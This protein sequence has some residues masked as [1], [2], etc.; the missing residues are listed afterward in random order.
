M[1]GSIT[2]TITIISTSDIHGFRCPPEQSPSL[3]DWKRMSAMTDLILGKKRQHGSSLLWIDN[4]D[5]YQGSPLSDYYMK[6]I[7][8]HGAVSHPMTGW[9]A[10]AGCDAF[11]PG[12]HEFNY[13]KETIRLISAS[14]PC[15]WLCANIV[16]CETL[17]PFFGA[18]YRI[19]TNEAGVRVAVLGLTTAYI[20]H[21]ELPAHIEGLT[22]LPALEAAR[23]WVPYLR[24]QHSADVVIV[25]YHGGFES[26]PATGE[27][28]E[29][30]TGENEGFRLCTE[31]EGI[32][33]LL[34][35]HQHRR[36]ESQTI[37]G[38]AIV[39]P[40]VYGTHL[41]EVRLTLAQSGD[42][43]WVLQEATTQLIPVTVPDD[44][45]QP[46][47]LASSLME[48]N[49]WM[50][51]PLGRMA[52]DLLIKNAHEARL[53]KHPFVQWLNTVQMEA[54]G[55]RVALTALMDNHA[56]GF[57]T[58]VTI[59]DIAAN[60]PYPNTLT[61]RRLS[62]HQVKLALEH[63]ARYFELDENGAIIVHSSFLDPKPQPFHYDMWDG[64]DY[65]LDISRPPGE[66]VTRL[67]YDG[68]PLAMDQELEVAMNHYRASGSG[69]YEMMLD[70]PMVRQHTTEI[71]ELMANALAAKDV[72]HVVLNPNW[73]V[74]GGRISQ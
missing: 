54:A 4:G 30:W 74:T 62:G 34:T 29:V 56:P 5:L 32:D 36:I 63:S 46:D 72:W 11:V 9:L 59:R 65:T 58:V 39:Q 64:I 7:R 68:A 61:V 12:N 44:C 40:G 22:F 42:G 16:D 50:D 37:G 52:H 15:P 43:R 26:D 8:D 10:A 69:G 66:R 23:R 35:G 28:T 19:W 13:G 2:T 31:V 70:A 67:L 33:V 18:P 38:T 51:E 6:R 17:E 49:R 21:W 25:S 60:Y 14:A 20:P 45:E 1:S 48:L 3:S 55:T 73:H 27:P 47:W 71:T 57:G 53:R 24:A 41:G